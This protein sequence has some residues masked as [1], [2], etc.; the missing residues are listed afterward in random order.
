[1]TQKERVLRYM[2]EFGSITR[3]EAMR[4]LGIGDLPS[5]IRFIRRDGIDVITEDE[6]GT[7]RWGEKTI[8]GRYKFA[9]VNT[10]GNKV[11]G[12]KVSTKDIWR[13]VRTKRNQGNTNSAVGE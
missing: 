6:V 1:M 5:V 12:S 9:E 7:N 13:C 2:E 8:Y 4:D 10:D 11:I 3:L